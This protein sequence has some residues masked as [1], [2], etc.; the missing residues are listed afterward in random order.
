MNRKAL[1]IGNTHG[2]EGVKV[3]LLTYQEYLKTDKG[4]AWYSSEIE[5]KPDIAKRDLE[6]LIFKYKREKYDYLIVMFSGHGGQKRETVLELNKNEETIAETEL[7][8]I[9]DRQLNIYDCCRVYPSYTADSLMR[10]KA[11]F[12]ESV[13]KSVLNRE[14][15]E[16]RIMQAIPQQVLLYSCSVGQVAHDS[17]KGG[18][19]LQNLLRSTLTV[20]DD[21][22]LVGVAHQ[23]A[24]VLTELQVRKEYQRDQNPEGILPKCL[25]SQQLVFAIKA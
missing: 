17:P 20:E 18:I 6:T 23:E 11:A 3:D 16:K 21:F 13:S 7:R 2:L 12:S 9:S 19:Y 14:K 22:K 25:S 15:Y 10:M 5:V 1:L 8:N 4:G 24:K